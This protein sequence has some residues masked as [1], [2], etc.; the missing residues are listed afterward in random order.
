MVPHSSRL[1]VS[2]G[3]TAIL[4]DAFEFIDKNKDGYLSEQELVEAIR[5]SPAQDRSDDEVQEEATR[6]L[7]Q[8]DAN[9]DGKVSRDE[10]KILEDRIVEEQLDWVRDMASIQVVHREMDRYDRKFKE[11]FGMVVTEEKREAKPDGSGYE[12]SDP[13][14]AE[15]PNKKRNRQNVLQLCAGTETTN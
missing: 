10:W 14:K 13:G 9:H 11:A 7:S 1:I 2:G 5:V 15:A 6:F 8:V 12:G 4:N 3:A